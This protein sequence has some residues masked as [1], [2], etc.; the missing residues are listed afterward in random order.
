MFSAEWLILTIVKIIGSK[1]KIGTQ[2]SV[3]P[4]FTFFKT[5]Q[6]T[7]EEKNVLRR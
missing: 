4:L 7:D 6:S 3:N 1:I 5:S 2:T